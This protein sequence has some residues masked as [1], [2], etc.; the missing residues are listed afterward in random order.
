MG[1]FVNSNCVLDTARLASVYQFKVYLFII[2]HVKVITYVNQ[3][4]LIHFIIDVY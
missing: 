2:T 3:T 4:T 1:Q